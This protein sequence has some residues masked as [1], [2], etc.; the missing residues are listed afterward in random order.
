M[1][2]MGRDAFVVSDTRR[3]MEV[4]LFTPDNDAM[5][6]KLVGAALKYDCL[7]E[8][9]SY[10]LLVRNTLH[11][12][13]MDPNLIPPFMLREA[14]I[15][16]NETHKIHKENPTVNDHA[17]TFPNPGLKIP[18]GLWGVFLYFPTSKPSIEEVNTSENVYTLSPN[19]WNPHAKQSVN[20]EQNLID[21]EGKVM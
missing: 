19:R 12:P 13:S 17:I 3:M 9:K 5:K 4:N 7:H 20:C 14:G 6:L 11:V 10:I 16:V 8:D 1:P 21:W 15:M 18:L 2:V